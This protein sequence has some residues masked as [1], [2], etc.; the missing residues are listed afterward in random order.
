MP[1]AV[2][3]QPSQLPSSFESDRDSS[4]I[5]ESII[6]SSSVPEGTGLHIDAN[7]AMTALYRDGWPS[8][9]YIEAGDG[10]AAERNDQ[11]FGLGGS[12]CERCPDPV[13]ATRAAV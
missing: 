10:G 12:D 7:R 6:W 5:S 3:A 11:W 1:P 13:Q 4:G 9:C 2:P 8:G